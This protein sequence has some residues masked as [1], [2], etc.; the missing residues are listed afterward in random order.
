MDLPSSINRNNLVNISIGSLGKKWLVGVV[1]QSSGKY[2][3]KVFYYSGGG[4]QNILKAHSDIFENK[5]NGNVFVSKYQGKIGFGGVS[6]SFVVIYGG[7]EGQAFHVKPNDDAY[8]ISN[9]FGIRVMNEKGFH[10][11][12]I[13][14]NLNGEETWYVYSLSENVPKLVKLF[15]NGTGHIVGG[16]DLSRL[17]FSNSTE[18][19]SFYWDSSSNSL[20][21][22]IVTQRGSTQ[23]WEFQDKGFDKSKKVQLVSS[24]ISNYPATVR[25]AVLRQLEGSIKGGQVQFYIGSR[26]NN[27]H[28]TSI[29]KWVN[30]KES[31]SQVLRWKA[32]V[33]PKGS[34]FHSPFFGTIRVRYEVLFN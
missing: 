32:E 4:F 21:G 10:P 25:R 31:S 1:T 8:N 30:L 26:D 28:K 19:A 5:K 20:K 18:D 9:L 27:W 3:G 22:K 12:A 2:R 7:Y 29:N 33:R 34:K 6:D 23:F 14:A 13:R 16:L 15:E 24:D 17:L 11:Q